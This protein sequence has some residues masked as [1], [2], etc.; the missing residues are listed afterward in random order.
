MS[1]VRVG[2]VGAGHMGS[3]HAAKLCE[4]AREGECRLV[5]VADLVEERARVAAADSGA[6]VVT[7]HRALLDVSDAMVVAVPTVRHFEV[8]RD[9]LAAGCHV[10]VEKPIAAALDEAEALI[11]VAREAQRVLHVGHLEWHNSAL[12][13]IAPMIR[14]LCKETGFPLK[15]IYELYPSGPAKGACKVAGLAKPTG[16]V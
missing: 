4:L 9:S 6:A 8:V 12:R 5:G 2:V 3:L 15:R 7:D 1:S 14:K 16:C 13:G 10:L 11:R